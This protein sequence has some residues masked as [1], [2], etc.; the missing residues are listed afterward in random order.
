MDIA[1]V[2]ESDAITMTESQIRSL[3]EAEGVGILALQ[4]DDLPYIIP[5]SFGYDGDSTLYFVYLLF[6]TESRKETL[7]NRA[8]RARFL[9]YRADSVDDW[10]SVS[11][12]GTLTRVPEGEW[13]DLRNAMENAW[14]P[15]LFSSAQP[16]R[17]IEGYRF[18]IESWTGIQQP[19]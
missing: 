6:G 17:G 9:V 7:S 2:V 4:T 11:M 15:N 3:L 19:G 14:H 10:Q 13:D 8:E 18:R 1:G 16:M 12:E 5:I